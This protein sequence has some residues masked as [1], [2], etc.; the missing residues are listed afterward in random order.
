[1]EPPAGPEAESSSTGTNLKVRA[2]VRSE[3]GGR[4]KI[5]V[6]SLHFLALKVQLVVLVSAFVMVS[7]IWSLL[8][9]VLPFVKVGACAPRATWS[10]RNWQSPWSGGQRTKAENLS[11]IIMS[12]RS[13]RFPP[14]SAFCKL[15]NQ[16]P[17]L[18]VKKLP[19]S[20][21]SKSGVDMSTSPLVASCTSCLRESSSE[22]LRLFRVFE[23]TKNIARTN[24]EQ[25]VSKR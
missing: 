5:L 9:A 15:K 8:F 21:S 7:T 22:E 6:V 1:M 12:N 20:T 25:A 16:A 19:I 13:S 17:T 18:P 11:A 23:A 4:K 24:N 10:R 3:S 14:F 2:P